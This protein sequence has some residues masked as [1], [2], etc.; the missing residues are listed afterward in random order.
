MIENWSPRVVDQLGLAPDVTLSA[1]PRLVVVRM[2]AFGISGPWRDRVGFAQTIEQATGLAFLTGYEGE[3]PVMPNGMCDPIAGVHAAI[4]SLVA[5]RER[6]LTGRGQVVETPMV[7]GA[8]NTA[9]EQILEYGAHGY[10]MQSMGNHSPSIAQD[11]LRCAGDD[12]WMAITLPDER[13]RDALF[14]ATGSA[15]LDELAAWCATRTPVEVETL[16]HQLRVPAARVSWAH[17][18]IDFAQ[19]EWRGFF[20]QVSHPVT[21]THPYIAFPVRFDSGPHR[22][23]REPS[24]T[25]GGDNERVLTELGYEPEQIASLAER[26][27]IATSVVSGQQGW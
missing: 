18:A 23:N 3:T 4:A 17:E 12:E 22:W 6:D 7:G 15:D 8:L 5:L 26:N 27:V 24:P 13:S 10:L 1:N 14:E 9:A 16:A 20:E 11:V 21:G 25:L 19:L 2:P